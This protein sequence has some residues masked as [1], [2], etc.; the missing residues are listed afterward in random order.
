MRE[1][2]CSSILQGI[3]GEEKMQEVCEALG[4]LKIYVPG[5]PLPTERNQRIAE[6]VV[7]LVANGTSQ[8]DAY[9][10]VSNE[11]G[12]SKRRVMQIVNI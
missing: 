4:G 6:E 3:I 10:A 12:L 1:S 2:S 8:M 5:K 9:E 11:F 7:S